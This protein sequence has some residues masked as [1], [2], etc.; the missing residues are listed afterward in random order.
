[1]LS[2]KNGRFRA[3]TALRDKS[4][5]MVTLRN[6]Q[7]SFKMKGSILKILIVLTIGLGFI[8]C[9]E[10]HGSEKEVQNGETV[11]HYTCPMHPQ[12]VQDKPGTCPI[13]KME[14]VFVEENASSSGLEL[15][16][17]QIQLAN[18]QTIK[19][20]RRNFSSSRALN[21][22]LVA[23]PE[24]S[25]LISARYPGR[26]ERLFVKETGE[27]L[28]AGQPIY[29]IYSEQLQSL[30]QDYLLQV[31]QAAAFPNEKIYRTLKDAAKSKLVLFGFSESQILALGKSNKVSPLITVKAGVSGVVNEISVSEGQYVA[32]GSPVLRL[33]NFDKLW[34]EADIYPEEIS[35]IKLGTSLDVIIAGLGKRQVRVEFVNPQ[36][37]PNTQTVTIRGT[38]DNSDK[39]LQPGMQASVLLPVSKK[40]E[41]LS[42]PLEAVIRDEKGAH[43]WVRTKKNTFSPRMVETGAEDESRVLISS[44]LSGGEDVVASGAYLLYSEYVLKKGVDA[45]SAHKH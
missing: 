31:K 36:V 17:S 10:K 26:I 23:N 16:E 9:K 42:L 20:G 15:S 35:E 40:G 33:E 43:V 24:A 13:C 29:Q 6:A 21:G 28:S 39:A 12:V 2:G 7:I 44:G 30:Q 8:A 3:G 34:L 41:A 11:G 18:I 32:E 25:E 14:L 37:E 5:V 45:V 38:I 19:V 27:R 4:S 1:V 22:R